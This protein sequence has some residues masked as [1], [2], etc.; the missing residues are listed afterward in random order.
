MQAVNC[1]REGFQIASRHKRLIPVLWLA[2][3]VPALVI[4]A[5]AAA[6]LAPALGKS[7]FADQALSNDWF[8]VLMEFR[9]SP[10]DA[11]REIVAR[12]VV[13]MAVLGLFV[14]VVVSSGVV[15]TLLERRANHPFVLGVRRNFLRFLRT[16]GVLLVLTVVV[17]VACGLMVKGFGKLAAAQADGRIDL[18]G[19]GA[20]AAVFFILWAPVDLAADLS[21]ISAARHDDR[22]MVKG[23]F[24]AW[25]TVIRQPGLFVPLY[26]FFLVLPLALMAVY[27]AL[28]SPWSVANV[29]GIVALVIAQ[30]AVMIIRA[31]FKLGFWGAE[32]ERLPRSGRTPLVSTSN[33]DARTRGGS[34]GGLL[35]RDVVAPSP[36]HSLR[37]ADCG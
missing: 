14:Q 18:L 23:F 27:Y 20:A 34:C 30:Q 35:R 33:K 16:T 36:T 3:L 31:F 32:V 15:E 8:P 28:R 11:L 10:A 7:L 24:R 6:N 21:R 9:T 13:V 19:F 5:I 37:I 12:G 17:S 2:P 22:S 26:L 29:A 4:G 25:W 1:V